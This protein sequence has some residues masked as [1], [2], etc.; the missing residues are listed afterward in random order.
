MEWGDETTASQLD[1]TK[2]ESC[3]SFSYFWDRM[4]DCSSSVKVLPAR[5]REVRRTRQGREG[6]ARR[7]GV[8]EKCGEPCRVGRGRRDE[9][10]PRG[11]VGGGERGAVFAASCCTS[12]APST[13]GPTFLGFA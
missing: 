10:G 9:G 2:A 3:F 11:G 7:G 5:R 12:A 13:P 1:D 8:A 6:S 4:K